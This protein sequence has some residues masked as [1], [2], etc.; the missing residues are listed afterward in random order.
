[1]QSTNGGYRR[2]NI[3]VDEKWIRLWD[4]FI[5]KINYFAYWHT[6]SKELGNQVLGKVTE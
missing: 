4:I 5:F 1:V 3:I 2:R 6:I